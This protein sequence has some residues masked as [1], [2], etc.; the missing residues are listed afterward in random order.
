MDQ[1]E[2]RLQEKLFFFWWDWS[3]NS[4]LHN[5]KAGALSLEPLPQPLTGILSKAN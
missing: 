3:L 1:M 2:K 4:G 5:H